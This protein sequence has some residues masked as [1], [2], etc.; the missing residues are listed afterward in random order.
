MEGNESVKH[1]VRAFEK[2]QE[3]LNKKFM[4]KS[5]FKQKTRRRGS[6]HEK[7]SEDNST[8]IAYVEE[9]SNWIQP[10]ISSP[11]DPFESHIRLRK[12]KPQMEIQA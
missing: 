4:E 10:T 11:N 8:S 3:E 12:K 2:E 6:A 1:I 7:K 9:W 5:V